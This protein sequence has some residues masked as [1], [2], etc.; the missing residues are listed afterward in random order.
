MPQLPPSSRH[1]LRHAVALACACACTSLAQAAGSIPPRSTW[2]CSDGYWTDNSCWSGFALPATG[3][4]VIFGTANP[5]VTF[6]SFATLSLLDFTAQQV[7]FKQLAGSS[8]QANEERLGADSP[9]NYSFYTQTG[10]SNTVGSLSLGLYGGNANYEIKSDGMLGGAFL[11]AT[12]IRIG[13][14]GGQGVSALSQGDNSSVVTDS[15]TL[16]WQNGF[17]T[18]Y[19]LQGGS[20]MVTGTTALQ[21]GSGDFRQ[22]GGS[23]KTSHLDLASTF[24]FWAGRLD[25][26]QI[27]MQGGSFDWSSGFVH[28]TDG[29]DVGTGAMP[30]DSSTGMTVGA[31]RNFGATA[32]RIV[33][34]A[35]LAHGGGEV[36]VEAGD[37]FTNLGVHAI[38]TGR[39][40]VGGPSFNQG[41]TTLAGGTIEGSSTYDNQGQFSGHGSIAGAVTFWNEGWL[42]VSGGTLRMLS[43]GTFQNSGTVSFTSA[44]DKLD[45][46][47]LFVAG[48]QQLT[49]TF[50]NQGLLKLNGQQV[51]GTGLLSNDALGTV[52]G[53]GF[54]R[55]PFENHGN[56]VVQG[57][58]LEVPG[59]FFNDGIVTVDGASSR[60]GLGVLNNMG[61][62][63]GNGSVAASVFNGVGGT[64]E[65]IGGTL[66]LSS[67]LPQ[68]FGLIQIGAGNKLWLRSGMDY[69][70]G[71]IVLSGGTLQVSG[72]GIGN[73]GAGNISGW[74]QIVTSGNLDNFSRLQFTGGSSQVQA[75]GGVNNYAGAQIIAS[76]NANVSFMQGVSL[77]SG[78][79]L[80]VSDGAVVTFFGPV[81][82][83]GDTLFSGTGSKH[84]EGGFSIASSGAGSSAVTVARWH[85][86]GSVWL[87]TQNVFRVQLGGPAQFDSLLVDHSLV[88][89]GTLQIVELGGWTPQA[90]EVFKL[91]DADRIS[92]AFS[93]VDTTDAP[94]ADGLQWDLSALYTLGQIGVTAVP[95][96]AGWLM[97]L[98]GCA[99]IAWRRRDRPAAG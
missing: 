10:G 76:G 96:P 15:L 91:F 53:W 58:S 31:G 37:T 65:P 87:G 2:Q 13:S 16:T 73:Q 32:L 45:L 23:F 34:G 24:H 66:T 69:N 27:N 99:W 86:A 20:L 30:F 54:L 46:A 6:N 79:E 41:V 93:F 59:G 70:Q 82:A 22:M 40:H 7:T 3:A 35:T 97:G 92:G 84:Y 42:Q 51:T 95:E 19:L 39:L 62:L 36:T 33:E 18:S 21:S 55:S 11:T 12:S 52:S 90:G 17:G 94:L 28:V 44:S 43:S 85:D 38:D 56:L 47:A 50:M 8:L 1:H 48:T 71:Q 75:A 68:N 61:L 98:A 63:Q 80:R 57:G 26:A 72:S 88:L 4:D 78:S 60:L 5:K 89:G 29:Y 81:T 25:V 49:P 67:T 83:A 9:I 64:I 74:G 14:A 77:Q